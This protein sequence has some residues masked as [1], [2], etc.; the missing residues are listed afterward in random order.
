GSTPAALAG[1]GKDGEELKIDDT[2]KDPGKGVPLTPVGG[3]VPTGAPE[4]GGVDGLFSELE[5]YGVKREDRSLGRENG[6]YVF[7]ASVPISGNGAKR[8][9]TGVG[10]TP[11]EAVTKVLDGGPADGG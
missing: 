4:P 1:K 8:Q 10:A 5:K 2:G 6:Q 11:A 3:T 7:R 9:Y